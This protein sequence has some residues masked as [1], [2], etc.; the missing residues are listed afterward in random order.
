MFPGVCIAI[1]HWRDN[2][3]QFSMHRS[4]LME[5]RT[6]QF[7]AEASGGQRLSGQPEMVVRRVCTDSR[8]AQAGDLFVPLSGDRFDGHA[9][10]PEAARRSVAGALVERAKLPPT[11]PGCALIAVDNTRAAFGRMAARYRQDFRLP[12]VAVG[13]SNGKTTTKELLSA[14]LRQKLKTLHSQASFN[15]DVGVPTT[16]FDLTAEHEAAVLEFG[17]NHPGELAPLLKLADP[18]IGVIT[19]IGREHLEFFGDLDGVVREEGWL[20]ELLPSSGK[21]FLNGDTLGVSEIMKRCAAPVVRVGLGPEND[22]RALDLRMDS[23]GVSFRVKTAMPGF[24]REFKIPL[25]GRHQVVNA[26]F[27]VAVGAELSLTPEQ[28]AE[29]LAQCAPAKMRLQPWQHNGVLVLDDS[30]NANADSMRAALDTLRDIPCEGRRVAVLG[31]MAELGS[32]AA[33]AHAEIGRYAAETR[34]ERL[35]T[36][37][38]MAPVLGKA[39]RAA[40]LNAVSEF[41]GVAE[42]AGAVQAFLRPMDVVLIKASRSSALERLSE[43]LRQSP[44]A[45]G[46]DPSQG[47]NRLGKG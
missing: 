6:L 21:L 7:M 23:S 27:A 29:G 32:H 30:Y 14:V 34:V 38:K 18:Q 36:I 5:P 13:G 47:P 19:S 4:L 44:A 40:G 26:L 3:K 22:W 33:E 39:A 46:H 35:F 16:L 9:F 17:T 25:L 2:G 31:D 15:N 20:A 41:D 43:L 24:G 42:A 1:P 12:I 10:L 37:G 8:Q 28:V 11:W 45:S